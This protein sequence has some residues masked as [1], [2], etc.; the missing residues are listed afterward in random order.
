MSDTCAYCA[1]LRSRVDEL[2]DEVEQLEEELRCAKDMHRR[3]ILNMECEHA[4]E[5]A[6]TAKDAAAHARYNSDYRE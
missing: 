4:E 5:L 6:E 2:E 3:Q 1:N